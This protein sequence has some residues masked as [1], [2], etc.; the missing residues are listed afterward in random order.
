MTLPNNPFAAPSGVPQ[1]GPDPAAP[2]AAAPT[3]APVMAAP[4]MPAQTLGGFAPSPAY[5]TAPSPQCSGLSKRARV[6]LAIIL[7]AR[8]LILI[9]RFVSGAVSGYFMEIMT[10]WGTWLWTV[11][12]VLVIVLALL[13]LI[14]RSNLIRFVTAGVVLFMLLVA[15]PVIMEITGGHWYTAYISSLFILDSDTVTSLGSLTVARLLLMWM[16]SWC[17]TI[18]AFIL[19]IPDRKASPVVQQGVMPAPSVAPVGYYPH[20][21]APA[22]PVPPQGAPMQVPPTQPASPQGMPVQTSSLTLAPPSGAPV[23]PGTSDDSA[24]APQ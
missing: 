2:S 12:D 15:D 23:V 16:L 3:G 1:P 18:A 9:N 14:R 11:F 7:I 21:M 19:V 24:P 6:C 17:G 4:T 22:Q 20:G 5:A 10:H 8:A 13:A